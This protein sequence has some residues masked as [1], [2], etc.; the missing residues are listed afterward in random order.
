[1]HASVLSSCYAAPPL[2][3]LKFTSRHR[4]SRGCFSCARS[5]P[6]CLRRRFHLHH[7][8]RF[9]EAVESPRHRARYLPNS[10]LRF[11][12]RCQPRSDGRARASCRQRLFR[13]SMKLSY[14]S[15]CTHA[16]HRF[17]SIL[18]MYSDR[19]PLSQIRSRRSCFGNFHMHAFI[20]RI[21]AE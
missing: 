18:E 6:Q 1:M 10:A 21:S 7:M 3:T 8:P 4:C 17:V 15:C 9:P 5:H 16:R 14:Q 20:S 12:L 11:H 2:P 13:R 19:V